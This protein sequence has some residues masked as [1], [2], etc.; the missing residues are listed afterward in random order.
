MKFVFYNFMSVILS[1][2]DQMGS[3]LWP[4]FSRIWG[5]CV[6]VCAKGRAM[7]SGWGQSVTK[8]SASSHE[9]RRV[10][11]R[12]IRKETLETKVAPG[13]LPCWPLFPTSTLEAKHGAFHPY[14]CYVYHMGQQV[15]A[16]PTSSTHGPCRTPQRGRFPT[17][18]SWSSLLQPLVS[19][20]AGIFFTV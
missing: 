4:L 18:A 20:I 10:A 3:P 11:V 16:R 8:V 12:G 1:T 17:A 7:C 13:L 5:V 6:C 15:G 9:T 2:T 19:R 14:R